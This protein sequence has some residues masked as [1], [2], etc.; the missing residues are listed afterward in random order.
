[1]FQYRSSEFAPN[2]SSIQRHLTA[3]EKE[4]EN[5]GR[6]AGRRGSAAAKS[7]SEQIGEVLT[8]ILNDMTERLREGGRQAM[9]T[10]SSYSNTA[11]KRVS[12][13]VEEQP[14]TAIA[15]AL[16]VGVLVGAAILGTMKK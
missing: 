11:I 9:Q 14:L 3:V 13:E 4:L 12:G 16:G 1:M 15:V 8:S 10:S 7:A 5:I 6:K 2:V